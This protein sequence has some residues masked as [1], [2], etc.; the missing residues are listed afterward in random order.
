MAASYA[1]FLWGY[2]PAVRLYTASLKHLSHH[3]DPEFAVGDIAAI[4][5]ELSHLAC[6]G[7]QDQALS[8]RNMLKAF[9]YPDARIIFLIQNLTYEHS[10]PKQP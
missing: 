8:A 7:L 2:R 1:K 6:N 3:D 5:A 4:R 9:N 10:L